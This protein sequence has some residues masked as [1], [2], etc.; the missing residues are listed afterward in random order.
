[1]YNTGLLIFTIA[2][3]TFAHGSIASHKHEAALDG[4]Y[5]TI[6]LG[7]IFLIS[8][9]N[10]YYEITYNL[11]DSVYSSCFFMLTGLHG[12]HVL[13]G[14]F[15]LC[16]CIFRLTSQDYASLHYVGLVCGI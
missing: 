7:I 13:V 6:V 10:E 11:N 4:L 15:F 8:Q 14:V 9:V 2:T 16:R 12:M 3:V 1:M 5:I